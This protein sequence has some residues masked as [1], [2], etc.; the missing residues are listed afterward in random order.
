MPGGSMANPTA[1]LIELRETQAVGA[2]DQDRVAQRNI[3]SVLD[4]RGRNKN[5][6]P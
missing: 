2:I 5:V 1:Q 4:D 6:G 3:Q